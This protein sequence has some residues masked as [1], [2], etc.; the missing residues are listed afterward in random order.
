MMKQG[1]F[2]KLWICRVDVKICLLHHT[3]KLPCGH[4]HDMYSSSP[5][6]SFPPSPTPPP[7]IPLDSLL[8]RDTL[9]IIFETGEACHLSCSAQPTMIEA[10]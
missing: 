9:R 10:R 1:P 6:A 2:V 5:P 8:S 4:A 3:A 7:V